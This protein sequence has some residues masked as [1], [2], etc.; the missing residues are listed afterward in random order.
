MSVSDSI[1]RDI[2]DIS[3]SIISMGL[4]PELYTP[5]VFREDEAEAYQDIYPAQLLAALHIFVRLFGNAKKA[6]AHLAA[7]MQAGKTGVVCGVIRLIMRNIKHIQIQPDRI[8][9]LTGMSDNAWTKQ[10]RDRVPQSCHDNVQHNGNLKRI[11]EKLIRL[12]K[13][14]HLKNVLIVLDESHFASRCTNRPSKEIFETLRELCPVDKWSE[15]NVRMITISATD[16]ALVLGVAESKP[17][18][19]TVKLQTMPD[20]QSVESMN[21]EG[22][23]LET[24]NFKGD[25]CLTRFLS[26]L[27]TRFHGAPL[28]HIM[29]PERKKNQWVREALER[30]RPDCEVIAWDS[31]A[32]SK[33]G[34]SSSADGSTI[35][36]IDD[37]N[38]ILREVPTKPTFIIIKDMFYASKT[39]CDRHVGALYDRCGAKDDTNLQ[40]LLGRGCGYGKS[41]RTIIFTSVAE[42][43]ENYL[44][45]WRDITPSD[46]ITGREA[47]ALSG[48]M[49]GIVVTGSN[50]SA[51]A[52]LGVAQT[53]AM[54]IAS[55]RVA[56]KINHNVDLSTFL[57]YASEEVVRKVC[58]IL[59]YQYRSVKP[60]TEGPNAGFRETSLNAKAAKVSLLDAIQHVPGSYGSQPKD[61]EG[62]DI[63]KRPH[64][65]VKIK[66]GALM[67]RF[68][69]LKSRLSDTRYSVDV[70]G[71]T[72]ELDRDAFAMIT[73]RTC[74]PCYKDVTDK[75]TLHYVIVLRPNTDMAA[76]QSVRH[77]YP[78]LVVPQV[79]PY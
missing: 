39:L 70:D 74:Y 59:G 7:E 76:L 79:G 16:P 66:Q 61:E 47:E 22:R 50:S 30:L 49:A 63:S 10:T 12:R 73:F 2:A 18:A 31:S 1:S 55:Q 4:V 46:H 62:E 67:G 77:T 32:S 6:W 56:P 48:K 20:Y 60:E 27:D 42:T 24:F 17:I 65:Y 8:F 15:N 14:G 25:A 75:D 57:V 11:K 52:V 58:E 51:S 28:Y 68:G 21:L 37:I 5:D 64:K 9:I 34:S 43:V 36:S 29:R 41:K 23:L 13:D 44:R 72:Y 19:Y 26:V 69:V 78:S 35:S 54:P 33:R 71:S 38:D 3:A 40:S 53:R 45:I